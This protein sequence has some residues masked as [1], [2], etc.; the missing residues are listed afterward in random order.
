[1]VNY[2]GEKHTPEDGSVTVEMI[3]ET[4]AEEFPEF[5]KIQLNHQ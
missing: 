5:V 2:I 1:M 4:M 3:V